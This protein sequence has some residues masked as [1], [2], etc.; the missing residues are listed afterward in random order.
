MNSSESTVYGDSVASPHH[1]GG[2]SLLHTGED[3]QIAAHRKLNCHK[4]CCCGGVVI[5]H[6]QRLVSLH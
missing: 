1:G 4:L 6:F 2:R 5:D 3:H